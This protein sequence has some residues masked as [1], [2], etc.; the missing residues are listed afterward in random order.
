M[1]EDRR[2]PDRRGDTNWK[3]ILG[4]AAGILLVWFIIAN[5]QQVEVTWWVFDTSTSLIV[6]ILISA[7]LGAGITYFLTRVRHRDDRRRRDG[8]RD[9][10]GEPQG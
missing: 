7:L 1:S 4:I 2:Q 10:R 5:A 6:V 9:D 3:A 8:S